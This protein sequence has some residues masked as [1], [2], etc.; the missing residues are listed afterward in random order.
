MLYN[1]SPNW[2]YIY[3][4]ISECNKGLQKACCYTN[5]ITI[6]IVHLG[7]R[8]VI[9]KANKDWLSNCVG[10][11]PIRSGCQISQYRRIL[12][13]VLRIWVEMFTVNVIISKQCYAYEGSNWSVLQLQMHRRNKLFRCLCSRLLHVLAI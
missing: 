6:H 8:N 11:G 10:F 9:D 4:T 5:A 7:R 2:S 13:S 3:E 12:I 1:C